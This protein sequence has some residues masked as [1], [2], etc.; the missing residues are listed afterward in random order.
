LGITFS[1]FGESKGNR[2]KASAEIPEDRRI[3]LGA[4]DRAIAMLFEELKEL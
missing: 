4:F 1:A 3:D 2:S